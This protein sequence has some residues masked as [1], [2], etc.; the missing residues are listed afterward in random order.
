MPLK[1]TPSPR[2]S[3]TI[4]PVPMLVYDRMRIQKKA[5][6]IVDDQSQL[7]YEELAKLTNHLQNRLRS[8]GVKKGDVVA[9]FTRPSPEFISAALAV[10]NIGAAY[11]PIAPGC[12]A[13]RLRF[14]IADSGACAL[15]STHGMCEVIPVSSNVSY[16]DI[17]EHTVQ[18]TE[19]FL[20]VTDAELTDLA[21]LIYTSGSTGT[22]KGVEIDH[23]SLCQLVDWHNR[24]F[25]ITPQDRT[26]QIA[27]LSFDAAVWEIWPS[28]VAGATLY[29]ADETHRK[30]VARLKD[31]LQN[32]GITVAFVPT[33]LAERLLQMP[34]DRNTSLRLLLTGGESLRVYPQENLPFTVI[35]NYGLTECTVVTTSGPVFPKNDRGVPPSIGSPIDG[36]KVHILDDDLKPVAP[37][38]TGEIYIGGP[39]LAVGY[40]NQ[41]ELTAQKFIPNPFENTPGARLFRTGDLGRTLDGGEIQFVGRRDDQVK[42]RG[43]RIE[44]AEIEAAI[45]R[46]PAVDQ[47]VV[48]AH[49]EGSDKQLI[50]YIVATGS[51]AN[52]GEV[53]RFLENILPD[54]MIPSDFVF[55]ERFPVTLNGKVDFAALPAPTRE[56]AGLAAPT[57]LR[58]DMERQIASTACSL[59]KIDKI[60]SEDNLFLFGGHSLFAAQ[61]IA[62]LREQ[63]GVEIQLLSVFESPTVAQIAVLIEESR[64]NNAVRAVAH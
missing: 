40:H 59:L 15:M 50:A 46:H 39:S 44:M 36:A 21:Y 14:L 45:S 3:K 27:S 18:K 23:Q 2:P 38:E 19:E 29:I 47:C 54:Y 12:P 22:P 31:W 10:M 16:I 37:G 35:N 26:T 33:V 8:T 17:Q 48:T 64:N 34:W 51:H 42:V 32:E 1:E 24:T 5:L 28:L 56:N 41:P 62:R 25:S 52:V 55:L 30:D 49:G 11:L 63:F 6:A 57:P 7:T 58:T 43:F 13:E 53:R 61:L 60:G 4:V 9:I 20:P